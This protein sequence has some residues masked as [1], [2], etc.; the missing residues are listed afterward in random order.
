MLYA[1]PNPGVKNSRIVSF[2]LEISAQLGMP[3]DT[4]GVFE[5]DPTCGACRTLSRIRT[6][7]RSGVLK[8]R[9]ESR[10]LEVLRGAS[11]ELS[12]LAEA[13]QAPKSPAQPPRHKEG[14]LGHSSGPATAPT[15]SGAKGG[16]SGSYYSYSYSEGE[17]ESKEGGTKRPSSASGVKRP[18][19]PAGPPPGVKK[20]TPPLGPPPKKR[21]EKAAP[22]VAGKSR[23]KDRGEEASKKRVIPGR[24]G[25]PLGLIPTGKASAQQLPTR[26]DLRR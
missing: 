4:C 18:T 6:L 20:P 17:E 19:P 11:G 10:V 23:V 13:N 16:E 24:L 9:Q 12:D 1:T 15:D 5:G 7:L 3:C 2:P 14:T 21:D 26:L 22:G 8:P 25:A